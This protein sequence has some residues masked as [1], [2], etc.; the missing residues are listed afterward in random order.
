M[1]RK[2]PVPKK[3]T[4]A[5]ARRLAGA[6]VRGVKRTQDAAEQADRRQI[7]FQR[8]LLGLGL[9]LSMVTLGCGTPP[10]PTAQDQNAVDDGTDGKGDSA[11][12]RH[13]AKEGQTCGGFAGIPCASGLECVLPHQ[14][15]FPDESGTCQKK[16]CIQNVLCAINSHFDNKKCEC[17]PNENP[18]MAAGGACVALAPGSCADGH[19]GDANQYSCGGGLGVEC[20]LPGPSDECS[21]DTDCSG[22]LPQFCKVCSDGATACAHWECVSHKCEIRT[23]N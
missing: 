16:I 15:P 5:T 23:C 19:V 4:H 1:D 12:R 22:F 14:P 7:M 8:M 18:C 2:G 21:A 13:G 20:C 11:A 3:K 10:A 9:A 6:R 17:V